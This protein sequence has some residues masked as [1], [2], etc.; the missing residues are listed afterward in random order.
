MVNPPPLPPP[1]PRRGPRFLRRLRGPPS[2][3]SLDSGAPSRAAGADFFFGLLPPPQN[4]AASASCA[5][6]SSPVSSNV[7]QKLLRSLPPRQ[8]VRLYWRDGRRSFAWSVRRHTSMKRRAVVLYLQ[9]TFE[10]S[11][12]PL[13]M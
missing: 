7:M 9:G 8:S 3:L 1:G 11:E 6:S 4:A 12:P 10:I 13:V 2:A 5:R